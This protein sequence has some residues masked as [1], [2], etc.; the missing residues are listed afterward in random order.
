[1]PATPFT[2]LA[3]VDDR[4]GPAAG[5]FFG[6]GFRRV[7]YAVRDVT[8]SVAPDL[9]HTTTATVGVAYPRDWSRKRSTELRPHFSTVDAIVLASDLAVL[10]IAD[11]RHLDRADTARAHVRSLRISAANRPQEDLDALPATVVARD[12][13]GTAD[14]G[15]VTRVDCRIGTMRIRCEV[16]HPSGVPRP[17]VREHTDPVDVLGPADRRYFGAGFRAWQ[18]DVRDVRIDLEDQRAD[19]TLHVALDRTSEGAPPAGT[20][21]AGVTTVD[22]FV[23]ALQLGQVLLYELDGVGRAESDTLWM[24]QTALTAAPPVPAEATGCATTARL[25][26]A[27][28]LD[29]DGAPWRTAD[30]V[31]RTA[32]VEVR[33]AVTHRLPPR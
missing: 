27:A 26:R 21:P 25:E 12:A 24:R 2:P 28:L 22:A 33:C 17:G 19:A 32:G 20:T 16:E 5:R 1:M 7:T 4:L 14:G 29:M 15:V 30:I 9:A 31:G 13:G 11:A 3:S 8:T 18:Q 23:T 10:G 6:A